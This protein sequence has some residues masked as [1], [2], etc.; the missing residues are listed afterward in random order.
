MKK[1]NCQ[2]WEKLMFNWLVNNPSQNLY[3]LET[4]V[5]ELLVE[6]LSYFG[7]FSKTSKIGVE[8]GQYLMFVMF[9]LG[10]RSN[11]NEPK[12]ASL[13]S[14][15]GRPSASSGASLDFA[16]G[17]DSSLGVGLV[18]PSHLSFCKGLIARV[19]ASSHVAILAPFT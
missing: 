13:K 19:F 15:A 6:R 17:S 12:A 14:S 8:S 10:C 11:L 5:V 1:S 2:F 16:V 4:T 18:L 3:G 9:L 7:Q